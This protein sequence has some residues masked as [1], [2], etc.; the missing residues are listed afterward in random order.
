M[1]LHSAAE[2]VTVLQ[3]GRF[4][5][6]IER[7]PILLLGLA[8]LVVSTILFGPSRSFCA[9][10]LSRCLNGILNG[11]LGVTKSMITVLPDETNLNVAW[12]F[13]LLLM[14]RAAGYITGPFISGVLSRP[15]NYWPDL[16]LSGLKTHISC[17]ASWP[18]PLLMPSYHS[19]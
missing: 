6:H 12:G 7:K 4:S 2:A 8:G 17:C 18:G 14:A 5:D 1:S 13:S 19:S 9:L 16:T 3:C 15:Q 10:I 11:N